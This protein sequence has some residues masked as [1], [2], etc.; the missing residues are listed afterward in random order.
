M[1]KPSQLHTPRLRLR[2]STVLDCES[3]Q[4]LW[5]EAELPRWRGNA[6]GAGGAGL[7]VIALADGQAWRA[8]QYHLPLRSASPAT[9]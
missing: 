1:L 8:R 6:P 2:P 9:P 5:P 3:M 7:W 4:P